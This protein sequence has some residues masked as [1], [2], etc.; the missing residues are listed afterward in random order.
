M[1]STQITFT[2]TWAKVAEVATGGDPLAVE[3]YAAFRFKTWVTTNDTAPTVS[4]G[5]PPSRT[6]SYYITLIEGEQL[7]C[8]VADLEYDGEFGSA[9]T[10]AEI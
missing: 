9:T 10:G 5:A 4:L 1:A 3:L 7:W 2:S 8:R 6:G